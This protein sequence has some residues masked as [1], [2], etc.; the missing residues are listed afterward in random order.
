MTAIIMP[1]P[2][3]PKP[4]TYHAEKYLAFVRKHDCLMCGLPSNQLSKPDNNIIA[5][6]ES[7]GLNMMG[8][9]PPDSHAVPL[10]GGC[11]SKRHAPDWIDWNVGHVDIKMA[12]IKLLTEY[13]QEREK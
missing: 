6:H 13:L 2:V 1:F 9:K 11:H 10:C 3:T 8:G 12:V 7:L 4:K 5:H